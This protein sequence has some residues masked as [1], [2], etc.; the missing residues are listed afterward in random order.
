[1]EFIKD[2][3]M[4]RGASALS[5]CELLSLLMEDRRMC[6]EMAQ[7]ILD[8]Y[9]GSLASISRA[10]LSQLRM[11][12]GL[13][14]SYACR[15]IAAGELGRRCALADGDLLSE[16][17]SSEDVARLFANY[18]QG[19]QHEECWVLYL[20]VANRVLEQRK[21]SQGGVTS[22]TVDHRII[23]K[24]A[25]ELLSTQIIILHNHPSGSVEPSDEDVA[26]TQKIKC[27]AELFDI[28]VLDHII[29]SGDLYYSF[30]G[31]GIL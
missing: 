20:N 9:S 4:V 11:V 7:S 30:S 14:L 15:I 21:V 24:R 2:K 6:K 8:N 18:M 23:I 31:S 16:I 5:D 1:M 29:L 19:L 28:K 12:G 13:G 3:L 22:T 10:D 27:A 25:L 17:S 26:L